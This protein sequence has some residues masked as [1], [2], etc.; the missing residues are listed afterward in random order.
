MNIALHFFERPK[1]L[2]DEGWCA[3]RLDIDRPQSGIIGI[4]DPELG[5]VAESVKSSVGA[6]PPVLRIDRY[7]GTGCHNLVAE[8]RVPRD[9]AD[10]TNVAAARIKVGV[11]LVDKRCIAQR[12]VVG[13]PA[14]GKPLQIGN[15]PLAPRLEVVVDTG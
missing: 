6:N 10:K 14:S 12:R 3:T 15:Q 13:R 8:A 7:D 5:A 11:P 9:S 2:T 4:D 1:A